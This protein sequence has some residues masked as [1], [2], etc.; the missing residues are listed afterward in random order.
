MGYGQGL[1]G[2]QVWQLPVFLEQLRKASLGA[3]QCTSPGDLSPAAT[4]S[5]RELRG[6]S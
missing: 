5:C 3:S 2:E 1:G 4:H 6:D